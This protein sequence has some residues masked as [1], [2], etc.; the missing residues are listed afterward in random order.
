MSDTLTPT[1]S[2]LKIQRSTFSPFF[3]LGGV[4]AISIFF[5]L[6]PW[7]LAA[8]WVS[9]LSNFFIL[10]IM[11]TMWNLLAGY[12]GMISIGQ[13]GFVGMG[14][15]ATLYFALK[16]MNPFVAIPFAALACGVIAIPIT[17]LLLRLRGGYFSV[18][19][20]VVADSAMLLVLS[21]AYLGGG[22]GKY[23]PGL[24]TLPST[25][26]NHDVYLATW[27]GAFVVLLGTYLLL[28][29]RVGLLL[30]SMR[31]NEVAARSAG[32][33]VT[34]TRRMIYVV[35]AIGCGVA[36]GVLSVS[37]PFVQPG[38]EFQLQFAAEMLFATM[39][40][41]LGTIEGP[42]LG[43]IIF[44]ALQQSLQNWGVWYLVIFGS[45]AVA[46][47]IWQPE[48]L[49]GAIRNRFHVELLPVGYRVK[50]PRA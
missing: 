39:I 23:M 46:I 40:G 26:L 17:F 37:Q 18:A 33:K 12:A 27:I 36:G 49:W 14:A 7:M 31:D 44:F 19:T 1:S 28:R 24:L 16:G 9:I 29:S 32:A 10:V 4:V 41:G 13:Q 3:S 35:V 21:V 38:N 42:I 50:E 48:G 20:W 8:S 30:S 22:T 11:A 45:L 25:Q 6:A 2:L 47:S 5:T 15:Y 34:S 43:S